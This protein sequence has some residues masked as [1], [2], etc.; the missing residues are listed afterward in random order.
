M[1]N[2]GGTGVCD[3]MKVYCTEKGT[4][5]E[6]GVISVRVD[7]AAKQYAS[8]HGGTKRGA[9]EIRADAENYCTQ[10]AEIGPAQLNLEG[11]N[12]REIM[13]VGMERSRYQFEFVDCGTEMDLGAD[14]SAICFTGPA[15]WVGRRVTF[16]TH[17]T[18]M[19]KCGAIA[20]GATIAWRNTRV[21]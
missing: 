14:E 15:A 20:L 3:A 17:P 2:K 12:A 19:R 18:F 8:N 1:L 11:T 13:E 7:C 21:S 16:C 4:F 10:L 9:A 5:R 6:K